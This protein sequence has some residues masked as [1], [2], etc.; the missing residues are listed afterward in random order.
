MKTFN[1]DN[2]LYITYFKSS[3]WLRRDFSFCKTVSCAMDTIKNIILPLFYA[4]VNFFIKIPLQFYFSSKNTHYMHAKIKIKHW[5]SVVV[6]L[7]CIQYALYNCSTNLCIIYECSILLTRVQY[8]YLPTYINTLC[9]TF[10]TIYIEI[11]LQRE[12][13]SAKIERQF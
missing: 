8:T 9:I 11:R 10:Y 1:Y 2:N 7:S 3:A 6:K 12:C 4:N 13:K 5:L